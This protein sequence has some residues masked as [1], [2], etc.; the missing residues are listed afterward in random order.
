MPWVLSSSLI[1]KLVLE[2]LYELFFKV[3]GYCLGLYYS[4]TLAKHWINRLGD[5]DNEISLK[6]HG[7]VYPDHGSRM[8]IKSLG[9]KFPKNQVSANCYYSDNQ[10][11][12][13]KVHKEIEKAYNL[14]KSRE[15]TSLA[16]FAIVQYGRMKIEMLKAPTIIELAKEYIENGYSV[17]IFVNFTEALY[18]I[19]TELKTD[20]LV[21]GDVTGDER[22]ASIKEFQDN[23]SKA[24]VCNI[25]SGGV[26]IS[27][28]D[29][30]GNHPRV[31]IISPTWCAQDLVQTLGRIHRAGAK[32]PALQRIVYCDGSVERMICTNVAKKIKNISAINDGD[33][34]SIEVADLP[35]SE[36]IIIE[37]TKKEGLK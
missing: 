11:E 19:A 9:D 31:S 15:L 22:Q 17:A 23:K 29:L 3:V 33:L 2:D 7:K 36:A 21:C 16:Y 37:K 28:H 12:I 24:I 10:D 20:T 26:G 30:H 32:T 27:L 14:F 34:N 5:N 13:Q 8:T 1:L 18:T 35:D 25:Q 6:L 4:I